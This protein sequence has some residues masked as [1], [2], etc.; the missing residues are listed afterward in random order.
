MTAEQQLTILQLQFFAALF[1]GLD[2]FMPDSWRTYLN[3]F[4]EKY[5]SGVQGRVDKDLVSSWEQIKNN[6]AKIFVSIFS[7]ATCFLT[8]ELT[9]TPL[10]QESPSLNSL[11]VIAVVL[12]FAAGFLPLF[13]IIIDLVVP[14]GFGGILRILTSFILGSP[15]GPLAAIGFVSLLLS[16][17][18]R[19]MY[20]GRV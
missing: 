1:M 2:Y 14:V 13:K 12:L 20:L 6:S 11:L 10:L 7:L 4:A 9:K 15:K 8:A 3:S 5:F 16:F 19:Y 17:L 18:F